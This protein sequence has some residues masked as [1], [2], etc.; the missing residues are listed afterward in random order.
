M[1]LTSFKKFRNEFIG[2]VYIFNKPVFAFIS[3]DF[4]L[5]MTEI[6]NYETLLRRNK[7]QPLV[8]I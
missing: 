7:I 1:I 2:Y 3:S 5:V 4:N 8:E 6:E